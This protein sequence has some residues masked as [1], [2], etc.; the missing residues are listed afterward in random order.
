MYFF[1]KILQTDVIQTGSIYR[2][3]FGKKVFHDFQICSKIVITI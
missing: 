2:F 3:K 1:N